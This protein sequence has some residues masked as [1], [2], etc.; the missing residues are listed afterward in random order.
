[1]VKIVKETIWGRS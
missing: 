1:M